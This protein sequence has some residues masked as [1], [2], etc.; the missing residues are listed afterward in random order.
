[1]TISNL[2]LAQPP[3]MLEPVVLKFDASNLLICLVS[4][5][6]DGWTERNL[7]MLLVGGGHRGHFGLHFLPGLQT[8]MPPENDQVAFI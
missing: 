1:M 7:D 5:K 3:G 6:A 8:G 4:F 2:Q